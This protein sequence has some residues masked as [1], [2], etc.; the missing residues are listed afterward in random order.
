MKNKIDSVILPQQAKLLLKKNWEYYQKINKE[1]QKKR[2]TLQENKY[3]TY[4]NKTKKFIPI[5]KLDK[6]AISTT[7]DS[8][9]NSRT[10]KNN[11]TVRKI[12]SKI[13]LNEG[14]I[15]SSSTKNNKIKKEKKQNLNS[16]ILN[17]LNYNSKNLSNLTQKKNNNDKLNNISYDIYER[18]N[19]T[20]TFTRN[21][22]LI[23]LN[24]LPSLFF[25]NLNILEK[26]SEKKIKPDSYSKKVKKESPS[27][28]INNKVLKGNLVLSSSNFF[29]YKQL[30]NNK[31]NIKL[32]DDISFDLSKNYFKNTHF[33]QR[34]LINNNNNN[35]KYCTL[36]RNYNNFSNSNIMSF[37]NEFKD[38]NSSINI[39]KKN[40]R[41]ETK[42][43]TCYT[44]TNTSN[45]NDGFFID[46]KGNNK[47]CS[48][49]EIHIAFVELI[50]NQNNLLNN[51]ESI[52]CKNNINEINN[53]EN[54]DN[55][56]ISVIYV[57]EQDL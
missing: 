17:I 54:N 9:L 19:S 30:K 51:Q 6:I 23:R 57:E 12:N 31:T 55:N 34:K 27:E 8:S 1:N 2:K 36:W 20:N 37:S 32:L 3:I 45:T 38:K 35:N 49:E 41:K 26:K 13:K 14:R 43:S 40:K 25:S 7:E 39:S 21:K 44:N 48:V 50:K 24:T 42:A 16:S 28:M 5:K 4:D 22:K 18:C 46:N 29:P 52:K 47:F 15:N 10:D 11:I 56:S 53:S 33:N